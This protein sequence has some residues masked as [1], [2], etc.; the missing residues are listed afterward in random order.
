MIEVRLKSPLLFVLALMAPIALTALHVLAVDG[1]ASAVPADV[2][3]PARLFEDGNTSYDS[4]QYIEAIGSY[5]KILDAGWESADLYFNLGNAYFESG[6]LGHSLLN[7]LRAK[8]L[9]PADEDINDNLEFAR[10]FVAVQMEGVRLNPLSDF[11]HSSTEGWPLERWGWLSTLSLVALSL[12]AIALIF[13]LA[14]AGV[15]RLVIISLTLVFVILASLTTF[16]YRSEFAADRAVVV[17]PNLPVTDRPSVD[18]D[19]EFTVA[20][21]LEI[22]ILDSSNGY[23]LALFENKRRGWLSADAVERL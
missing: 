23:Y 8:R 2:V 20:A 1:H 7:Y 13:D 16:K 6:D 3:E 14:R 12:A 17:I 19:L 15:L 22:E 18:G 11:L 10:S 5:H 4:A 21:G 9:D